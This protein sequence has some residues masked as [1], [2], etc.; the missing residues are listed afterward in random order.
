[1]DTK[2]RIALS[3]TFITIIP[4]HGYGD[5][6]NAERLRH[7][8]WAI[9]LGKPVVVWRLPHRRHMDIPHELRVY[10]DWV[11]IDGNREQFNIGLREYLDRRGLTPVHLEA[12][13]WRSGEY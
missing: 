12:A 2:M 9:E 6:R 3:R 1:M 10:H 7:L 11:I 5:P 13:D 4:P 8:F